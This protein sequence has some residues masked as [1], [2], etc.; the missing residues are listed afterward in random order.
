MWQ[1]LYIIHKSLIK[2]HY[3]L[4]SNEFLRAA[5]WFC[6]WRRWA[7]RS[8]DHS[9]HCLYLSQGFLL[10]FYKTSQCFIHQ[11]HRTQWIL[12]HWVWWSVEWVTLTHLRVQFSRILFC[13]K[14]KKG[15]KHSKTLCAINNFICIAFDKDCHNSQCCVCCR[16]RAERGQLSRT[17]SAAL[18]GHSFPTCTVFRGWVGEWCGPHW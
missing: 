11:M 10:T 14:R 12:Q 6:S 9:W 5:I 1:N 13:P 2:S 7:N 4:S 16:D 3:C 18:P 8:W 15:S 17:R